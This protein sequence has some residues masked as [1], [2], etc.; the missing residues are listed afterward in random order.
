MFE[1][2]CEFIILRGRGALGGPARCLCMGGLSVVSQACGR[3][4]SWL[5]HS[6]PLSAPWQ[7]LVAGRAGDVIGAC[8]AWQDSFKCRGSPWCAGPE[9]RGRSLPERLRRPENP[10]WFAECVV[11]GEGGGAQLSSESQTGRGRRIG[12]FDLGIRKSVMKTR[13]KRL[14]PGVGAAS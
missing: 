9:P 10:N 1:V 2:L 11:C 13:C 3:E 6:E 5:C 8:R 14:V 7:G 4:H 12:T